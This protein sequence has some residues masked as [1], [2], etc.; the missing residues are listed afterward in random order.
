MTQKDEGSPPQKPERIAKVMA[1]AG[2]CSRREAE[3]WIEEGRVTLNGVVLETP[4]VTVT[5]MD[6][7]N[8]DGKV[9]PQKTSTKLWAFH[10]PRG[11]VTTHYDP[12]GRETL[13]DILPRNLLSHFPDHVISI[14]RLDLMSEGIILLTNDGEFA[15]K[16]EH[17]SSNIPRTYHVRIY[18]DLDPHELDKLSTGISVDNVDYGPIQWRFGPQTGQNQ[19]I[20]M[21]LYEGKNREIR[22]I[23]DHLGGRVNRLLRV[24]YG[25][26]KLGDLDIAEGREIKKE[27]FQHLL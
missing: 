19:W 8:V 4:A 12:D 6:E 25:P 22:K 9:L 14:G 1:R 10:K 11:V 21:T 13:F 2:L 20:E 18:G 27:D 3:R 15:R 5:T 16:L 17:P 24:S 23:V 7:I 26:F